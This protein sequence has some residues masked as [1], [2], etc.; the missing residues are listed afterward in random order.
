[1]REITTRQAREDF[2]DELNRVAFGGERLVLTRRGKKLAAVVPISDLEQLE[3][4]PVAT[5][6]SGAVANSHSHNQ[7]D[8]M[9]EP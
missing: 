9:K 4:Q 7:Q 5:A 8:T 1:M 6:P 2:S 3:T